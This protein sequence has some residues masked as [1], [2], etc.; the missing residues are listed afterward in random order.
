[1]FEDERNVWSEALEM[2]WAFDFNVDG[3]IL[4]WRKNQVISGNSKGRGH[5]HA[6]WHISEWSDIQGS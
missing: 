4:R 3:R 6:T 5:G 1:M 2:R